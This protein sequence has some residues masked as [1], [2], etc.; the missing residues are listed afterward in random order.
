LGGPVPPEV[1]LSEARNGDHAGGN[2][3]AM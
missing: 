1:N 2:L 3:I